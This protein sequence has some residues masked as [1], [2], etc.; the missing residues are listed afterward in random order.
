MHIKYKINNN[1]YNVTFYKDDIVKNFSKKIKSKSEISKNLDKLKHDKKI[2][3]AIDR[4]VNKQII[5]NL[6]KFI[7]TDNIEMKS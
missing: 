7:A 4:K 3:L 2:L 1:D 5:Q 6:I